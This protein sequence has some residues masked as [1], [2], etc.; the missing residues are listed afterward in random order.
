MWLRIVLAQSGGTPNEVLLRVYGGRCSVASCLPVGLHALRLDL[1]PAVG[2]QA[3]RFGWQ[4]WQRHVCL[5]DTQ[6]E[7]RHTSFVTLSVRCS[8]G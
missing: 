6:L 2:E 4:L 8:T 5:W 1:V 3:L 7:I